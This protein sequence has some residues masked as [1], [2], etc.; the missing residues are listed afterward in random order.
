MSAPEDRRWIVVGI[1]GSPR[2]LDAVRWAAAEAARRGAGLR[3]VTA[4]EGPDRPMLGFPVEAMLEPVGRDVEDAAA[5]A[6]E[7]APPVP[8]D[9]KVEVGHPVAVLVAESRRVELLVVGASGFGRIAAALAG[10][11]AIGAA[12][13]A[14]C[15]VVVVRGERPDGTAP[16]VL[17]VDASPVGEGAIAFAFEAAAARG[18]PLVAVRTSGGRRRGERSAPQWGELDGWTERHPGVDV[19]RIVGHDHPAHRL[20]ELSGEAQL[21]VVGSR[22]HGEL[23]GLI[24]DSVSHAMVHGAACPVAVV[25][26]RGPAEE[27]R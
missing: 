10:S 24:L 8:L 23:V 19:R 6:A 2:A 11:V 22:G 12:T 15:P 3:L 4:V 21:V 18:V 13:H 25:R 7:V 5:V 20:L 1:D 16:V 14:A 26:P 9:R 27:V 17:G